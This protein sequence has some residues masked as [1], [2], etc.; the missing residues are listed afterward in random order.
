M[1]DHPEIPHGPYCYDRPDGNTRRVCP[2]WKPT[3]DGA[4]C[5]LLRLGSEREDPTNL[6]WD[7]VKEC[8]INDEP[9]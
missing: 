6:V 9:E 3:A 8:G 7:Q 2:H 1:T 5:T 4:E